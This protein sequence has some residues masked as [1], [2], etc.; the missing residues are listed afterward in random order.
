MPYV[1]LSIFCSVLR[2]IHFQILI[3]LFIGP[4]CEDPGKINNGYITVINGSPD[5][6]DDENNILQNEVRYEI[7]NKQQEK[8]QTGIVNNAEL[9][10]LEYKCNAG[11]VLWGNSQL[12]C[13][14]NNR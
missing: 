5:D 11:Y 7:T 10:H 6:D 1:C 14:Y 13:Q 12:V 4:I 2:M 8:S 3:F 9:Q